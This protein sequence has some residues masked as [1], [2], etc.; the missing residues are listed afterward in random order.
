MIGYFNNFLLSMIFEFFNAIRFLHKSGNN[1]ILIETA[2]CK[3]LCLAASVKCRGGRIF[4]IRTYKDNGKN[5]IVIAA[6]YHKS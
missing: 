4:G 2:V 5:E 1:S 6:P 3:G